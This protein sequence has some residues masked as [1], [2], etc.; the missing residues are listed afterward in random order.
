MLNSRQPCRASCCVLEEREYSPVGSTQIKKS[1]ARFVAAT[2]VQLDD[3][4][5]SG[6][7]REDLYYRL[8]VATINLPALRERRNDIPLLIDVLLRKINRDLQKSIR[9]VSGEA[10]TCLQAYSWPGNVR[11]LE[12]T[13]LKAAVMERGDTLT[14]D[15][16]LPEIINRPREVDEP[17]QGTSEQAFASLRD[18]ERDYIGRILN[19]TGWH[20]GKACQILGISRPRLERRIQEFRLTREYKKTD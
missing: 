14:T 8:N 19:A 1:K 5:A 12:N 20:K 6:A 15:H 11:Q 16:L 4:V 3:R 13:L 10:M 7:F 18:L 2:N 9:R 17:A